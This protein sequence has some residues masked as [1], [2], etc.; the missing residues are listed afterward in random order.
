MGLKISLSCT[1]K[2]ARMRCRLHWPLM[3]YST[4]WEQNYTCERVACFSMI[5]NIF[6][7]SLDDLDIISK[8]CGKCYRVR[9]PSLISFA[10]NACVGLVRRLTEAY[11]KG[12]GE[13]KMEFKLRL[14]DFNCPCRCRSVRSP[15][16]ICQLESIS[17]PPKTSARFVSCQII[18]T[19][20][21]YSWDIN[22]PQNAERL[23]WQQKP[24][25]RELMG[26][27][28]LSICRMSVIQTIWLFLF[29][30]LPSSFR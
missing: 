4:I 8:W 26:E 14:I 24:A 30:F 20:S 23:S 5:S 21:D 28:Y 6:D 13:T 15:N 25:L 1:T 2:F 9:K 29:N 3:H 27:S 18:T 10:H 12:R 17:T 16:T 22:E 11:R 7:V 19:I